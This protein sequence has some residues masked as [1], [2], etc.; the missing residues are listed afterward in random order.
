MNTLDKRPIANLISVVIPCHN[1]ERYLPQA[2]ESVLAQQV[3]RVEII[4]VDDGSTDGSKAVANRFPG[5]TYIY[6]ENQGPSAARNTGLDHCRGE[7]VVF[8]DADDWLV[9]GALSTNARY[10]QENNHIAFVSGAYKDFYES[11]QQFLSFQTSVSDRHFVHLLE[12]NYI[13]M[14][15]AVMFRKEVVEHYR[16]DPSLRACEDYDL[17]LRIA[18]NHLILH[19]QEFIAI[20][21][22]HEANT[23]YNFREMLEGSL[24]ALQR[25]KSYL[26]SSVEREAWIRGVAYW[27]EYYTKEALKSLFIALNKNSQNNKKGEE[28]LLLEYDKH[29]YLKY[30]KAKAWLLI[31]SVL[32]RALK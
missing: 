22:F 23:S 10:L 9:E 5:V 32:N 20:Y 1:H 11:R 24:K 16:F 31:K 4:I 19:H 29:L 14:I 13:S 25:Q 27:K 30:L 17:Y 28:M 6:Q 8:L 21:R 3:D 2:I 7:F 15:A 12:R 18:R 26:K